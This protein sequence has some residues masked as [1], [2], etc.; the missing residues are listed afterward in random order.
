MLDL[1]EGI[2]TIR[3]VTYERGET[4]GGIIIME[5]IR[6]ERDETPVGGD[7]IGSGCIFSDLSFIEGAIGTK[8]H[9]E[10]YTS[11]QII[12][13]DNFLSETM[14]RV[15]FGSA[16]KGI[17]FHFDSYIEAPVDLRSE[18]EFSMCDH[19]EDGLC[20]DLN[21]NGRLDYADIVILFENMAQFVEDERG[22]LFD[23]NH[24]GKLDYADLVILFE[25]IQ[26]R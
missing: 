26:N 11:S 2:D 25:M 10:A 13:V 14:T 22:L 16:E 17:D 12:G 5:L 8:G 9:A 19:D 20:E 23:F 6:A 3:L 15:V 7:G 18:L 4:S 21:N 1:D 24:N